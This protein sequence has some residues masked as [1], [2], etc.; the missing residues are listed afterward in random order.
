MDEH[1]EH[2]HCQSSHHYFIFAV[3][4]TNCRN[5]PAKRKSFLIRVNSI[6]NANKS[7]NLFKMNRR[8]KFT[9]QRVESDDFSFSFKLFVENR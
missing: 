5:D 6:E 8:T 1:D 3:Y 7:I 2:L 9:T 4:K